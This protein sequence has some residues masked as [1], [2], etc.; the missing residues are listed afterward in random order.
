L[1]IGDPGFGSQPNRKWHNLVQA[2]LAGLDRNRVGVIVAAIGVVLILILFGIQQY[3]SRPIL[4][5]TCEM[6]LSAKDDEATLFVYEDGYKFESANDVKYKIILKGNHIFVLRGALEGC[7]VSNIGGSTALNATI[8]FTVTASGLGNPLRRFPA[9][10]VVPPFNPHDAPFK[11]YMTDVGTA[12][13]TVQIPD[14]PP[15]P[16]RASECSWR[17]IDDG[18]PG[19]KFPLHIGMLP[20]NT[21]CAHPN[22]AANP[23]P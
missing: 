7:S 22:L 10:V 3:Q 21:P 11:F 15:E 2:I 16:F 18:H 8:P 1:G 14:P 6:M 19:A 12:F 23:R 20:T 13:D 4:A 5:L 9:P 17:L